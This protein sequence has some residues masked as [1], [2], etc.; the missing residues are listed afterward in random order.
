VTNPE[1]DRED[2]VVCWERSDAQR[3]W[4][5]IRFGDENTTHGL[6]LIRLL[7]QLVRQFVQPPINAI[8]L[9]VRERL[10]IDP[11]RT[12]VGA[13]AV[14]GEAQN[15]ATVH[16]VIQQIEAIARRF[17]RFGMQ[18]LLEF[19][20]LIWRCQAHANLP[21]LMLFRTSVLNSGPFAPPELP[22]FIATT[23]P[24]ATPVGP[25]CPSRASG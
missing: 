7:P 2:G 4:L 9:D 12:T 16:L 11:R 8:L 21:A 24:S 23:S 1:G 5:A 20:N 14:E 3:P 18:R 10:A 6:R 22:G 17:L 15:V 13:A 25:A 19:P